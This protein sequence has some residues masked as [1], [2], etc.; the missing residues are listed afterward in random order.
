MLAVAL[1]VLTLAPAPTFGAPATPCSPQG[2]HVAGAHVAPAPTFGARLSPSGPQGAH[3]VVA[4]KQLAPVPTFEAP[5]TLPRGL[6]VVDIPAN[7]RRPLRFIVDTGAGRS[8]VDSQAAAELGLRAH[9]EITAK[10]AGGAERASK[11]EGFRVWLGEERLELPAIGLPLGQIAQ[12]LGAP[13]EGILGY[14]FFRGRIV[15]IDYGARRLRVL[16]RDGFAPPAG[17]ASMSVKIVGGRPILDA[18]LRLADGR[19]IAGSFVFDTG[20]NLAVSLAKPFAAK[21]Q[22]EGRA[23]PGELGGVGGAQAFTKVDLEGVEFGGISFGAAD[24]PIF[25]KPG[26]RGGLLGSGLLQGRRLI[27]DY[28]GGEI[29]ISR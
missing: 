1:L 28:D 18:T 6:P 23:S 3:I 16:A 19:S 7:G 29:H 15:E 4:G 27:L 26:D 20:A 21:F 2:A 8:V 13:F 25:D 11:L 22:V 9:G 24:A 17:F 14:E 10:G 5:L 12:M